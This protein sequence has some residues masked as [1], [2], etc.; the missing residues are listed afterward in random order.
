VEIPLAFHGS[1]LLLCLIRFLQTNCNE[2]YFEIKKFISETQKLIRYMV[3]KFEKPESVPQNILKLYAEYLSKTLNNG[4]GTI[5]TNLGLLSTMLKWCFTQSW[6]DDLAEEARIFVLAVYSCKPSIPKNAMLEGTAL[7]MSELVD[8]KEFDDRDLLD[9]LN[10]FCF[11]FLLTFKTHR[12]LISSNR[13]VNARLELAFA[14]A[15]PD[16]DWRVRNPNWDDYDQIFNSI[17]ESRDETLLERLLLS[18]PRHRKAFLDSIEPD[19]LDELYKKL[20]KCV[21]ESG[22]LY[23]QDIP[24][25]VHHV[26]F[27]QLDIRSILSPCE[28]EEICLR[29]LLAIDRI[30]LSGQQQITLEDIDLTPTHVT[31]TFTK[32]RSTEYIRDSTSHRRKTF[33]YKIIS[34]M[35]GLREKFEQ[36]FG[37]SSTKRMLFQYPIAHRLPQ[38]HA[39]T[40]LRP[41]I[42]ACSPGT[43]LY[44][45]I[46][47]MFPRAKLFQEYFLQ[48]VNDN[49]CSSSDLNSANPTCSQHIDN[50]RP[51]NRRLTPNVIAQS[52]AIIDPE[53]P[54]VESAFNRLAIAE[55]SADGA[56]HSVQTSHEIYINRSQTAHRLGQR[57]K[58]V[59]SVGKLQEEDA[60]KLSSL[61]NNT[62]IL[63][64]R[65]VSEFLGWDVSSFKP[66]DIDD[67]NQLVSIAEKE[68]FNCAPFGWLSKPT[69]AERIIIVSPVTAALILSFI[70]GCQ[71]E[72]K[73]SISLERGH[74]IILKLSYAKLVLNVFDRRTIS[75]GRRI[76]NE[77]DIPP[78]II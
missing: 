73:K 6:F 36:N 12:D 32:R 63:S 77:Y 40:S 19:S 58:F 23:L 44:L 33:N 29:W 69:S 41:I 37:S 59:E 56:A 38:N 27:N 11:G 35:L 39:S 22:S 48:L 78:A 30:Q 64:L 9:S 54:A 52:R 20:K 45:K 24:D 42:L 62:K 68:G 60:R 4:S 47:S 8:S 34:Y 31:I 43:N 25:N 28:A 26:N 75:E 53:E 5:R 16:I 10:R 17:V 72:L 49:S 1:T 70:K 46:T 14:S 7:A 3:E 71:I 61:M 57:A 65:E 66:T 15:T 76:L 51:L 21:R 67:F 2:D 74:A 50:T 55:A 13:G 18:N